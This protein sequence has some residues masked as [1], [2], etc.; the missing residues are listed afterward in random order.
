[1]EIDINSDDHKI[2]NNKLSYYFDNITK[3]ENN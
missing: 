2:T 1:M 3:F